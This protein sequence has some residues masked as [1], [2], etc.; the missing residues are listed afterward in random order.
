MRTV[1]RERVTLPK[2]FTIITCFLL[3]SQFSKGATIY[4][5]GSSG[6]WSSTSCWSTGTLPG[7]NDDVIL[8]SGDNIT[9]SVNVSI[10]SLTI[11]AVDDQSVLTVNSGYTFNVSN[12][13]TLASAGDFFAKIALK[14]TMSVGGNTNLNSPSDPSLAQIRLYNGGVLNLGGAIVLGDYGKIF[15]LLAGGESYTVRY[16]GSSPQTILSN[17][18]IVY[19][20][21][22][23]ANTSTT[24]AVLGGALTSS[25]LLGNMTVEAGVFDNG[26]KSISGVVDKIFTV[27]SGATFQMS[28]KSTLPSVLTHVINS[29]SIIKYVGSTQSV[30]V[31]NNG[32]HYY[33]LYIDGT[34]TKMLGGD[35]VIDHDLN[36]VASDFDVSTSN[37]NVTVNGNWNNSGGTFTAEAGTVTLA[38]SSAQTITANG[39]DFYNLTFNNTSTSGITINDDVTVDNVATFTDG[40]VT[41]GS[42]ALILTNNAVGAATGYSDASFVNGYLR[43]TILG[44]DGTFEF[45]VGNGTGTSNYFLASITTNSLATTNDITGSFGALANSDNAE[46]NVSENTFPYLSIA[47]TG[48][49]HL[50]ADN[51]PTG[52]TY[53][54]K[55]YLTNITDRLTD[56]EFGILKRHDGSTTAADWGTGG[57][58]I[59]ADN[60]AGRL[61]AD[62]YALRMGLNSFSEFGVGRST[63]GGWGLP[64]EI[65]SF[66]ATLNNTGKVDLNW[67]TA[68]ETN[69]NFFTV[70]RSDNAKDFT[71]LLTQQGAGNSTTPLQ[72]HRVDANPLSGTSYYRL[73]QTDFDGK[74]KY[75]GLVAVSNGGATNDVTA[76]VSVYPNPTSVSQPLSLQFNNITVD[77][78]K[79]AQLYIYEVSSG[80]QIVDQQ[81][82]GNNSKVQLPSNAVPGMYL[83]RIIYNGEEFKQQLIVQ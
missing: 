28:N 39:S 82:T 17:T 35:I 32:Q 73:K 60:G 58:T 33:D 42:N 43:R 3:I 22:A 68:T 23:V 16:N 34:T 74:S 78:G 8:Q 67:V 72:Y 70:E 80:K 59:N 25:N 19:F 20:N 76:G 56:N 30:G 18:N 62:G 24:G 38:G 37:F 27:N 83:A 10:H 4:S 50:V 15:G 36:L 46:L 57:G 6:S 9:M 40:V 29:G 7:P 75:V 45:P 81:L 44:T 55:L 12:D 63:S 14:G 66:T 11:D 71:V 5:T 13:I 51:Q 77:A 65:T 61:V 21:L 26:G 1:K 79:T 47:P 31:P 64:V 48:T 52:G 41:T 53:D 69:N 2:L 54:V 49:W